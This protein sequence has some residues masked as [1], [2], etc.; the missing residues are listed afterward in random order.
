MNDEPMMIDETEDFEEPRRS[1][2]RSWKIL[3]LV[4][5]GIASLFVAAIATSS[6]WDRTFGGVTKAQVAEFERAKEEYFAEAE[7]RGLTD[8]STSTYLLEPDVFG[9]AVEKENGTYEARERL[10]E[11]VRNMGYGNRNKAVAAFRFETRMHNK[12]SVS[13]EE[14]VEAMSAD[15]EPWVMRSITAG[16]WLAV[17]AAAIAF[18]VAWLLLKLCELLWWFLM[19]R[20]HDVANAVRRR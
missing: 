14:L 2:R 3:Q 11:L 7:K 19:D 13:S 16:I 5:A 15:A 12:G 9:R 10:I 18:V 20:L 1:T 6:E 4:I 8:I 17:K